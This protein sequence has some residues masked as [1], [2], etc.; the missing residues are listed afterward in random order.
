M[1]IRVLC[2][3]PLRPQGFSSSN[4]MGAKQ[5]FGPLR[6]Q[7][8]KLHLPEAGGLETQTLCRRLGVEGRGQHPGR[9]RKSFP[10]QN[11]SKSKLAVHPPGDGVHDYDVGMLNLLACKRLVWCVLGLVGYV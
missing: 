8:V 6:S 11:S 4:K 7:H 1:F 9:R 5:S 10:K 2:L 3:V